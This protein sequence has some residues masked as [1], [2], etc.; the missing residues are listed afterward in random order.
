MAVVPI[1]TVKMVEVATKGDALSLLR[2]S[3]LFKGCKERNDESSRWK[4]EDVG[5]GFLDEAGGVYLCGLVEVFGSAQ[6]IAFTHEGEEAS[7]YA[8]DKIG[9]RPMTAADDGAQFALSDQAG[10]DE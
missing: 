6:L 4:P 9:F 3:E 7:V 8:H 1:K 2:Q 10:W 5:H